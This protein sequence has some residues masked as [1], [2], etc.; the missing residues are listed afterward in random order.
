MNLLALNGESLADTFQ[1]E[2]SG[3][4]FSLQSGCPL[5]LFGNSFGAHVSRKL[6]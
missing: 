2:S 5:P 4:A 6:L 3:A 1:L